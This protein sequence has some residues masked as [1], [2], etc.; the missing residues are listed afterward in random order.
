MW[1]KNHKQSTQSGYS[2]IFF[3]LQSS[4][5]NENDVQQIGS[6]FHSVIYIFRSDGKHVHN[7]ILLQQ[8]IP[9]NELLRTNQCSFANSSCFPTRVQIQLN[10]CSATQVLLGSYGAVDGSSFFWIFA[11]LSSVFVVDSFF[12][13]LL[14]FEVLA[15]QA[16]F[17]SEILWLSKYHNL[18]IVVRRNRSENFHFVSRLERRLVFSDDATLDHEFFGRTFTG[19]SCLQKSSANS[20]EKKN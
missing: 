13:I 7:C 10:E 20:A 8:Q 6:W 2:D 19:C 16:N 12:W 5:N 15:S 4:S 11:F 18:F 1:Q 14:L 3:Y 17:G 9:S